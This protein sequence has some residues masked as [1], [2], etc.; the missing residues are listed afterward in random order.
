MPVGVHP[1]H[2]SAF[3]PPNID[4]LCLSLLTVGHPT[5][6]RNVKQTPEVQEMGGQGGDLPAR[7][8]KWS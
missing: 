2:S 8:W 7:Q 6:A 5:A 4:G 1:G 3:D